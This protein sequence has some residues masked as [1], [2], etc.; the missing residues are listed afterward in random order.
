MLTNRVCLVTGASR[1]VGK[2]IALALGASGATV[3]VT[4]RSTRASD[5]PFG[6]T[7]SATADEVTRRGGRGIAIACDHKD[8]RQVRAVFERI[9]RE[10]RRLDILVN[11][12]TAIPDRL[13]ERGP[14]WDKPL[15]FADLFEV[16]ARSTYVATWFAAP[17]LIREGGVVVNISSPGGR[18]YVHGPAYGGTK[19][20]VDKM[21]FDM[22]H[23]F[24]PHGVTVVSLWL[25]LVK[26]EK[27]MSMTAEGAKQ[28]APFLAFGESPEYGGRILEALFA[29]P[30]RLEQSGKV[31]FA[32]ELAGHYGVK[33]LNGFEPPSGR[34]A[35][36]DPPSY[37]PTVIE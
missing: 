27:V 5:S 19:A 2:G 34:G 18:C 25:G 24:K 31:F 3:Y 33:D 13:T 22:A 29:D 8:D 32:A 12:A 1:G 14:F 23:D 28:Y 11:N 10:H 21:A 6:G 37:S 26:T 16:G 17:M 7:V 4:G 9:A 20:A 30:K 36:G 35:L 15:E